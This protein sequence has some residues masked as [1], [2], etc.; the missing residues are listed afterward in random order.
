P[1]GK[2]SPPG[3]MPYVQIAAL[4]VIAWE[5]CVSV[6]QRERGQLACPSCGD[7]NLHIV[8]T[9]TH[10]GE[11]LT[12]LAGDGVHIVHGIHADPDGDAIVTVLACENCQ[13]FISERTRERKGHC[14]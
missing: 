8:G 3:Q 13:C 7:N 2:A 5:Y 14:Y 9:G 12:V 6:R 10:Q 11:T 4:G 1:E